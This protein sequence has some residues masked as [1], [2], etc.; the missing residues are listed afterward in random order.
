MPLSFQTKS[1]QNL[2]VSS[3]SN[4]SNHGS[5]GHGHQDRE[6]RAAR[7]LG[8][9]MGVFLICWLPFLLWMPLTA[10]FDL[11]TPPLIYSIIL[12]IGYGNSVINPFIYGFFNREFRGV[13]VGDLE[14]LG[15]VRRRRGSGGQGGRGHTTMEGCDH[16]GGGGGS[17]RASAPLS[18]FVGVN[19][20]VKPNPVLAR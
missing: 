1:H 3:A 6:S 18:T 16:V 19:T 10:V 7:T 15:V 8:I 9:V 14:R 11:T 5:F 4:E 17:R 20:G 13:I 2:H 12:W